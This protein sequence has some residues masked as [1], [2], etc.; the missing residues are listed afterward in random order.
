MGITL[1]AA[2]FL[3]QALKNGVRFDET[4]T[5]GRQSLCVSP[6]TVERLLRR[7]GL[8]NEALSRREFRAPFLQDPYYA[9]PFFH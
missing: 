5:I 8:W 2:E 7:Y 3:I 4:L 1:T 6:F 9:E